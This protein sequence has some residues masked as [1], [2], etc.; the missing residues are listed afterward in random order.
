MFT[1]KQN[2]QRQRRLYM[3]TVTNIVSLSYR[4]RLVGPRITVMQMRWTSG[5]VCTSV[6]K[7]QLT[8]VSLPQLATNDSYLTHTLYY[9]CIDNLYNIIMI[10]KR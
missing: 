7:Q 1:N 8:A 4:S 2:T 5:I 9:Y 10:V 6:N 3:R